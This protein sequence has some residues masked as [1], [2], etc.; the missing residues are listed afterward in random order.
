MFARKVRSVFDKL[1]PRQA[2]FKKTVSPH[3]KHFFPG[4]KVL[5]KTYKKKHDILGSR[6]SQAK[7][8]R[9]GLYCPGTKKH[10]QM[11]YEPAQDMPFKWIWGI[12]TKYLRRAD[13]RNIRSFRSRHASSLPGSTTLGKK[14]KIYPTTRR[15][16]QETELLIVLLFLPFYRKKRR[17]L[18]EV[19]WWLWDRNLPASWTLPALYY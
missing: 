5:F 12:T 9:T 15:K 18:L 7:D 11:P 1:I 17:K 19:G 4:N 13:R 8:W 16:S 3:K 14:K 6:H 2:K 10:P